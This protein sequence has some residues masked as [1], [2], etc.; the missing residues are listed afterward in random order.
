M[1]VASSNSGKPNSFVYYI[2]THKRSWIKSIVW[3]VIGIFMLGG[4]AWLFTHSWEQTS[5]ITIIF[6]AI[7]TVLYYFHERVWERIR[8]GKKNHAVGDYAI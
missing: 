8:W 3:R 5:L 2:D 1:S 6:H 4:I 7:R